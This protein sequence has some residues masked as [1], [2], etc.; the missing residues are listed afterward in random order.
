MGTGYYV[1]VRSGTKTKIG[2]AVL[3]AILGAVVI[4]CLLAVGLIGYLIQKRNR[5]RENVGSLPIGSDD[6]EPYGAVEDY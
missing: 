4:F 2:W 3:L 6:F 5:S 1:F